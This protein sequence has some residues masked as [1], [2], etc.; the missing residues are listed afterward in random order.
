M[1]GAFT[2]QRW[3][4]LHSSSMMLVWVDSIELTT[5]VGAINSTATDVKIEEALQS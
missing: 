2:S 1:T 5:I 3:K 4:N